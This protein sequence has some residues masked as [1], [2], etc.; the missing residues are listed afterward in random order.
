MSPL[1][2]TVA[3]VLRRFRV[4]RG[5]S[6]ESLAFRSGVRIASL[7]R[8]ERGV[9]SPSWANVQAVA[10]A[11]DLTLSEFAVAVETEQRAAQE[12]SRA[13]VVPLALSGA[14]G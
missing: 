1:D 2:P 5:I 12:A 8:M 4:Q 10:R 3:I 13:N 9:T 11:M 6:Q 7:S 14:Q